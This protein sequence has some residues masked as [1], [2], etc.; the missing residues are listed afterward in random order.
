MT[1]CNF[2]QSLFH[3]NVHH[4]AIYHSLEWYLFVM[5]HIHCC[6]ANANEKEIKNA[7]FTVDTP[8]RMFLLVS[9]DGG[10][11]KG[12]KMLCRTTSGFVYTAECHEK[13]HIST[14][15]LNFQHDD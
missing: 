9:E 7:Q 15:G 5:Q 11:K 4:D 8:T 2:M 10:E 3:V 14:A 1:D 6:N 13:L 12:E